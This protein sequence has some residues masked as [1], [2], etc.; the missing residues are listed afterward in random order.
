M[1]QRTIIWAA[2]AF[3]TVIYL[4]LAVMLSGPQDETTA[5]ARTKYVPILYG[6]ALLSFLF[7]WFVI[8]RVVRS[9]RRLRMIC[10]MA[11]FE[12]AAIFGLVG[13]I[14]TRDWRMYLLPWAMALV[15]FARERPVH[16]DADDELPRSG[17]SDEND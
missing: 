6:A 12:S 9:S 16:E 7:G 10:A 15:G 13:A 11:I 3:S 5:L 17:P 2:I 1:R 14:A 4:G 8:P